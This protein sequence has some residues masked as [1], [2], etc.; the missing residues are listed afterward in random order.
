MIHGHKQ[1][2]DSVIHKENQF[3]VR[4][5]WKLN[6]QQLPLNLFMAL[7]QMKS[8][9]LHFNRQPDKLKLCHEIIQ[10]QLNNKFIKVF[11]NDNPKE[12]HYLPHHAV[13]KDSIT[14]PIRIVFNC[15][16]KAK[17]NSV[18]LNDCL[19]TGP[20]LTQRLYDVLLRFCIGT[21]AYKANIS[22]AFLKVGLQEE[23]CNYI[24]FLWIKDPCDPLSE[25]ITYRF[26]SV[27][28]GATSST[29][30]L[31]TTLDKHL[32]KSNSP[33]KIE[34]SNNLYVDNFQGTTNSDKTA[35]CIS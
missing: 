19:Q 5:P 23:D 33:N 32:K 24:K 35:K 21:Y 4:L 11:T 17:Q 18:S 15:S 3:W 25:M 12:G 30:L 26:A 2:P 28:F 34:I 10:Q 29:F 8:Q 6:H 9:V 7:N 16:D 22:K 13:L 14:T 31:Q 20:S 1:Y 27:F